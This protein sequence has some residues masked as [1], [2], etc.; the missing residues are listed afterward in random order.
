[1][2][3]LQL[4]GDYNAAID[5][6]NK[7]LEVDGRCDFAWEM[8]GTVEIKR[9]DYTAATKAFEKAIELAKFEVEMARLYFLYFTAIAWK[10]VRDKFGADMSSIL[11]KS[12]GLWNKTLK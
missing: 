3:L 12:M 1:M 6:I 5:I 9:G 10:E 7:A 11:A 4:K 2:L 8:L